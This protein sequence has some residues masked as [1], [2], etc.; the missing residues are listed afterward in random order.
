MEAP[1]LGVLHFAF[2]VTQIT[3]EIGA[4]GNAVQ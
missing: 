4:I 3:R 1:F 2:F